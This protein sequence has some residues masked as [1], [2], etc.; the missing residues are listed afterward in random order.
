MS[1][2]PNTKADIAKQEPKKG[3]AKDDMAKKEPKKEEPKADMAKKATEREP[4][5]TESV[6]G[7]TTA[8]TRNHDED[9]DSEDQLSCIDLYPVVVLPMTYIFLFFSGGLL[10]DHKSKSICTDSPLGYNP[11][12]FLQALCV[13]ILVFTFG[14]R[15]GYNWRRYFTITMHSSEE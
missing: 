12:A 4:V 10:C 13:I 14:C 8:S 2:K 15:I 6:G 3:K 9:S 7:E 5:K 1:T 11:L